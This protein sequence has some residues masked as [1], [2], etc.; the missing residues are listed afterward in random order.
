[1]SISE[2]RVDGVARSADLRSRLGRGESVLMPGIW[3][4]LS[5]RLVSAT[6]FST[7]FASGFAVS[8]TLLGRPDVGYLTQ[9][10]MAE[11]AQRVCAAAPELNIVVD[12]DTGYGNASNVIR[13]VE[14]WEAAGATGLFLEDQVWPK[15]CGHM[16]D[17]RVVDRDEWL[18]KVRAACDHRSHLHVTARTD[19]R[20]A[21]SLTEALERG[22]MARDVG[23]DAVFIEAPES[24]EE[25]EQIAR[26]LPDV[27]LVANM[28]EKGRTPL[29]TPQELAEVGFRLIVSPLSLLFAVT[30]ALQE[31]AEHLQSA[32]SM[33]DV[34]DTLVSFDGFTDIVGLPEH[35][36]REARYRP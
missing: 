13:T 25:M 36:Q 3:D 34:M 8:G 18:A 30:K 11:V 23:V 16:S 15:K 19:A 35:Q 14:L 2:H 1:M 32:G 26:A 29:L 5:A 12:A 7:A 9:M 31:A 24:V 22:R 4:A 28:V 17:K 33:R 21:V 20:A 10:E 27:I 6:G